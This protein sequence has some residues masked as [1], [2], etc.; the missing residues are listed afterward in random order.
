[1]LPS[2]LFI[3]QHPTWAM[4]PKGKLLIVSFVRDILPLDFRK[5][6]LPST[7]QLIT[8]CIGQDVQVLT[9]KAFHII[10]DFLP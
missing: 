3:Q 6:C 9:S 7:V 4:T 10:T 1:M 8:L 2:S 5:I